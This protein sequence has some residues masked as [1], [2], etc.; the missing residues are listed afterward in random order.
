MSETSSKVIFAA[1]IASIGLSTGQLNAV[2]LQKAEHLFQGL[3]QSGTITF[4]AGTGK[5]SG[6]QGLVAALIKQSLIG[7]ENA[8]PGDV[9][10]GGCY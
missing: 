4:S 6:G 5:F 8:V 1:F 9:T 2:E 10:T 7:E 3:W